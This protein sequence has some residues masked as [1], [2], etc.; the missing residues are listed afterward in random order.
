MK[1]LFGTGFL[2]MFV[3]LFGLGNQV[4]GQN[5]S[6]EP[7]PATPAGE[8]PPALKNMQG[9]DDYS[10]ELQKWQASQQQ[11]PELQ[12][13]QAAKD[14]AAMSAA[15][16]ETPGSATKVVSSSDNTPYHHYKGITDPVKAKEAWAK[17][18]A[19]GKE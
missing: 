5:S 4:L 12:K 10:K 6:G 19:A 17:D 13:Q 9:S 14:V 18:Q 3:L 15:K 7:V 2:V 16:L 11:S 8:M 1:N